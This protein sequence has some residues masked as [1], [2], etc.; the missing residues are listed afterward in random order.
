M[1]MIPI[2][3]FVLISHIVFASGM[4]VSCSDVMCENNQCNII[5]LWN[6]TTRIT[7]FN[8]TYSDEFRNSTIVLCNITTTY[9]SEKISCE[10]HV[11]TTTQTKIHTKML[12]NAIWTCT[13]V[14]ESSLLIHCVSANWTP[15]MMHNASHASSFSELEP[16]CH[17]VNNSSESSCVCYFERACKHTKH[18]NGV[19][20]TMANRRYGI[21]W[22][23]E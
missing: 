5:C 16:I 6:G 9:T 4:D 19:H 21:D 13:A 8:E 17:C 23:V 11:S 2:L 14:S 1:E 10:F 12:I 15:Y 18:R 22:C 7:E 3:F 20:R